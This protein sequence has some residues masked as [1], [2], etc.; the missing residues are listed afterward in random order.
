M[1]SPVAII[2][3][4]GRGIGQA[5]ALELANRGHRLALVSRNQ[6]EL[7]MVAG[8]A[9]TA[10]PVAADVTRVDDVQ[11]VVDR[12]LAAYGRI[13]AIVNNVGLSPV[14]KVDEL[15]IE[16]WHA[17]INTNLSSAFYLARAVWGTF[18]EQR[19][20]CIVNI[21]SM[22]SRD[23]L[24]GFL[25]YGAAK[26][27]LNL[28]SLV[29]AREGAEH[30][31]RSYAIAPGAVETGM[32]RRMVSREKWPVEKTMEPA[33]VARV[34]AQCIDGDLKYA[35]GEVIFLSKTVS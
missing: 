6:K 29:L 11:M 33:D 21:S 17:V 25:A 32:F 8:Q 16:Q 27:G 10:I 28:M 23:P 12:T 14:A 30:G 7:E 31:I 9:R 5:I 20:G 4:A 18:K 35:S 22:A 3:G 26:A 34:V 2:T 13:D 24:P 1:N 19:K 15:T